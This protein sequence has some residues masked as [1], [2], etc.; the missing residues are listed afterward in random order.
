MTTVPITLEV[1]LRPFAHAL[2]EKGWR[3]DAL[4][5]GASSNESVRASF[6]AV[7][8]AQWSRN[9][10]DPRNLL[11][12]SAVRDLVRAG[13]YDVV[14]VHT[15]VASFVTRFA[16]RRRG[17][18]GPVVIYTAH[19]FHFVRGQGALANAAFYALEHTAA[20][21]TD[22]LVV[23]NDEDL[24]AAR[25]F[26]TIPPERV[27]LI[28]GIGVDVDAYRPAGEDERRAARERLGLADGDFALLMVAEFT[29]NKRHGLLLKALDLA[30]DLPVVTL[31]CGEGPTTEPTRRMA[32]RLGLGSQVRFLGYRTDVPELL[33]A[34]DA[35]VLVS[36]R[37]GLSR[38]VLEALASGVPVIGTATRGI[39]DAVGDAGWIVR[40]D[41]AELA[42]AI[43]QAVADPDEARRRGALGRKRAVERYALPLIVEQYER[44]YRE[45]LS[46][47][48]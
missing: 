5:A 46:N 19:G 38:S 25:R 10:L 30:R 39:A 1:F 40:D 24:E 18:G 7:H 2:R 4:A 28:P 16:L 41:P 42:A 12:A 36:R 21:W 26:G 15:P 44:L 8:D 13:G 23:I 45:A 3:V 43:R 20:G 35:L 29:R 6:D 14:H 17:P 22:W 11:E 37:E 48:V 47:R 27:R 31:L 33:A 34:S 9:P 32:E